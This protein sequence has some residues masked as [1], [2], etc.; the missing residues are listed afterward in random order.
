MSKR[1]WLFQSFFFQARGKI[2]NAKPKA[3]DR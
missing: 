2:F 1:K 3:R